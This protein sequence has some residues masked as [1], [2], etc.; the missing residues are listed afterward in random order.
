MIYDN[1]AGVTEGGSGYFQIQTMTHHA[2]WGPRGGNKGMRQA[3]AVL[4]VGSYVLPL[5][6]LS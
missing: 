1:T 4:I 2:Q 6:T 5:I 3:A